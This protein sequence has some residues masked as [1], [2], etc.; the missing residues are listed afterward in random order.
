MEKVLNQILKALE[1]RYEV[2][3]ADIKVVKN[4]EAVVLSGTVL[5]LNKSKE[6]MWMRVR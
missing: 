6:Q 5:D 1:H 4:P 3:S 2:M